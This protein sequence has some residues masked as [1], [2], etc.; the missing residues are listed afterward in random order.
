MS[1]TRLSL[2][3]GCVCVA[4]L[5]AVALMMYS[6]RNGNPHTSALLAITVPET[7]TA[8][9]GLTTAHDV[10]SVEASVRD[11]AIGCAGAAV[12]TDNGMCTLALLLMM[13][14]ALRAY[15]ALDRGAPFSRTAAYSSRAV[16]YG[17]VAGL[18]WPRM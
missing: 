1:V 4:L 14:Y 12:V 2:T 13:S 6:R 3:V 9:Y 15:A 11:L 10:A 16:Y 8:L 5:A 18:S 17:V 7:T